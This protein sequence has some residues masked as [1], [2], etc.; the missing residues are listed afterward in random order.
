VSNR[1]QAQRRIDAATFH[2]DVEYLEARWQRAIIG[3]SE[4]PLIDSGAGDP[5]VFVPTL[6]HFE[7]VYARQIQSLSQERRVIL[8]RRREL[9]TREIGRD[10]RVEELRTVLDGLGLERVDLVGHG[11]G[12]IVLLEF[13]LRYPLRCRSLTLI[14][15]GADYRPAP[16]PLTRLVQELYIRLPLEY[17]LPAGILHHLPLNALTT[18]A[19]DNRTVP[20]LPRNLV[21]GQFRKIYQW[22]LVF[23]YSVLP[24]LYHFDLR[25]QVSTLGVPTLLINR[26]DDPLA[27]EASTR[28]LAEHLPHC[29]GYH[30]VPGREHFFTYSQAEIVTPLIEGFL[31]ARNGV[32]GSLKQLY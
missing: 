32:G 27:P 13:A 23:K 19:W 18:H 10:E 1:V 21:E 2:A 9:R 30:I 24:L 4:V 6:E 28:W 25:R 20:F 15:Q 26:E 17:V 16:Y 5:L 7:F 12:A 14:A 11:N 31:R 22:P 8:Y 29:V 3:T